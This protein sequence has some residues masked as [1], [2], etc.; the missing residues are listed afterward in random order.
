MQKTLKI[1]GKSMVAL[2]TMTFVGGAMAASGRVGVMPTTMRMPTMPT[3]NVS[4]TSTATV[5]TAPIPTP[6]PDPV[7]VPD[8]DPVEC[9]DG[10]V[11]N[12]AY[13]VDNCMDD[14]LNCVNGGAL[15]NGM[16]DLFD[17]DLRASIFGGMNLCATQVDR[18]ISDVRKNCANVYLSRRDVW[19]DFDSR[20]I[21][22]TYYY[23]VLQRT[24]LTP[25]QAENTCLLL[26]KN[27]YGSSFTAVSADNNVTQEYNKNVG[28]YNSQGNGSLIK[29]NPMGVTVNTNGA[30]DAQRGHYARW[31]AKNAQCL[32]RIAAYNKDKHITN[33]WLGIGDDTPAEVWQSAGSTFTCNKDLFGFSLLTKTKS[34]A[35]IAIPGGAIVG[36]ATGAIIGSSMDKKEEEAIE[37]L[38]FEKLC[39]EESLQKQVTTIIRKEQ[40]ESKIDATGNA[41]ADCALF[42]STYSPTLASNTD[43]EAQYK[44][45]ID[46]GGN[47]KTYYI[48]FD[49][50][51]MS[52]AG[53]GALIGAG[54]GAGAGG[55]ATA[56]TAFVERNNI[57]CHVGDNLDKVSY[58]KS[59]S[60]ES[61]RD[62][63]VKWNLNLPESAVAPVVVDSCATWKTACARYTDLNECV[64]AQFNYKQP[65]GVIQVFNACVASGSVCVENSTLTTSYGVCP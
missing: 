2:G 30:V 41:E 19:I 57:T 44:A 56:I 45:T 5:P 60:I 12:S 21:Q 55:I 31:D 48:D 61:L 11:K 17:P 10:G 29:T 62:F 39:K 40:L 52:N 47:P 43:E 14:I 49:K 63:Y 20:K 38:D 18:C 26:D 22:P 24:G 59:H 1:I 58:N 32:V 15:P 3:A 65:T 53:K 7:P 25:N 64:S 46:Q 50:H 33:K 51:G 42:F 8:P 9:P 16:N 37:E 27:T 36:A 35:L 54:A 28:A 34:A 23:F 6:T 4:V 13:T